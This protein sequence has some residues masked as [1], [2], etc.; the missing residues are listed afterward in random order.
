L[1]DIPSIPKRA[2]GWHSLLGWLRIPLGDPIPLP[3][4][5]FFFDQFAILLH[6][7]RPIHQALQ[8]AVPPD[9]PEL[10]RICSAVERPL[11]A[12]VPLHRALLPW[13]HRLPE[14]VLPILEVG[15]VSGTLEGAAMRLAEAFG[16]AAALERRYRTA[17]FDPWLVILGITL[18]SAATH[19]T[20]SPVQMLLDAILTFLQFT[21]LYILGRLLLRGLLRWEG[22]RYTLDSIKLA[23]PLMGTVTRNLA[24][25]RWA[26]SF[27]VL[28][29]SGV[30]I[31]TALEVSSRSAQNACYERALRRAAVQTQA[32][33]SLSAS[34]LRTQ[35]LPAHLLEIVR[36]GETT[37]NL[38]SS[39]E[40]FAGLLESEAFTQATQQFVFLVS[41][42][43]LLATIAAVATVMR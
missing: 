13:K 33:Q 40:Q 27:A 28:W 42:G 31:S 16:Q 41:V 15:E 4:L 12:G 7:G 11:C 24:A 38:G 21:A 34:L 18:Y 23:L 26:R 25:A 8:S 22:L 14:I 20:P 3:T 1:I 37:G 30:P 6:A 39:L 43:K 32:G 10:G 19:F 29:N 2:S 17:F 36:T 35:L 5:G 9:A